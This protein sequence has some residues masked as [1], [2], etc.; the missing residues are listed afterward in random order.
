MTDPKT[1]EQLKAEMDAA[2]D[3]RATAHDALDA[4]N[5]ALEA[6]ENSND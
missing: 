1:L 6:Q 2:E 4:Y 5:K 3:A